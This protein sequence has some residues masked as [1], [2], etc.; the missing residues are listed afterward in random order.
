[1]QWRAEQEAAQFHK[2]SY[3][4]E[5]QFRVYNKYSDI[6]AGAMDVEYWAQMWE[7]FTNKGFINEPK[8]VSLSAGVKRGPY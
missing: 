3:H 2:I 7:G 8:R 4:S 1:M 6:Y 5:Q